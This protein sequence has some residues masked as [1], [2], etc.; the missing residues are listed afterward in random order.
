MIKRI[1][2]A[3]AR[4]YVKTRVSFI[5]NNKTL[6][7]EQRETGYVVYSYGSHFPLFIYEP[8]SARWYENEDK[9]SRTTS[10]HRTKAHPHTETIKLST[11]G[12]TMLINRGF[13]WMC[14]QRI[15]GNLEA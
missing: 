7:S 12:M 11:Y 2:N 14:E 4:K 10:M 9:Y 3:E 5:T 13:G 1:S 6:F 15:L 8:I